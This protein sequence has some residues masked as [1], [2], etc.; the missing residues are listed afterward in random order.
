M[1]NIR[2]KNILVI[3][4]FIMGNY[5]FFTGCKDKKTIIGQVSQKKELWTCSMHPEII[6]DKPGTCPICG[7]ELIK[8]ED[9]ATAITNIQLG[10]LLQPTDHFV[11]SAIPVTTVKRTIESVEAGALGTVGYDTRL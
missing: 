6:R 3:P 7:M 2:L 10:D 9:N 5:I 1:N 8:K 11:V 4:L